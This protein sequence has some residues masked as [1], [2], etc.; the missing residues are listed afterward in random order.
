MKIHAC[1]HR[2]YTQVYVRITECSHFKIRCVQSRNCLADS[3]FVMGKKVVSVPI[4]E[5][6]YNFLFEHF[7]KLLIEL[8]EDYK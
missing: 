7:E 1:L 2:V 8:Q 6:S 5:I 4:N 3:E